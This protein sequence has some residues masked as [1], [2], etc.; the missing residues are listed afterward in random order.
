VRRRERDAIDDAEEFL[1]RARSAMHLQA[2][3]RA[4]RLVLDLQPEV[5]AAM[6]FGDEP[7]LP[8]VDGLMR[9]LFEHARQVEHVVHAVFDRAVAD[10][11]PAPRLGSPEAVLR[12]VAETAEADAPPSASLLDA[13]ENADVPKNVPWTPDILAAFMRILRSGPAGMRA[14][15]A[16]DRL[17]VLARFLPAW[18]DVRCRPQ[19]DP[20]HRYTVDGHLTATVG[21]AASLLRDGPGT[22]V[23]TSR[24]DVVGSVDV[25]ENAN[26]EDARFADRIDDPDALLLGGL[27]HDVGKIGRGDHV[28]IG[29]RVAS[30][31]MEAMGVPRETRQLATF[32]VEEH[33]LLPDTATR[34]DLTDEN[35]ILD[36]AARIGTV[37]RLSALYLLTVADALATGPAAWTPWRTALIRDLVTKVRHVLERGDMGQELATRL[38]Q[39]TDRL[40]EMLTDEPDAAVDRFV[41]QMPRAYFLAVEPDRAARHFMTIAP[42]LGL[43]EVRTTSTRGSR[44]ATYELLVVAIDRPG[45][46]SWIAGALTLGGISILSAQVFTTDDGVAVDLFEVEGA[47]ETV[48]GEPRWREFRAMLRRAIDGSVSLERRVEEKRRRYPAPSAP[49]PVTVHVDNDASDFSSVIEVGAPDRIGLLYDVTRTLAD[50]RVDVHLAKVSTLGGRV[51]DAFYVRDQLGRKITDSAQLDELRSALVAALR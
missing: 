43:N 48:I 49:S 33:L 34:R 23:D 14:L 2:G 15:E 28:P 31:S 1:V 51:V 18:A 39:R 4:D 44:P 42:Q 5:A 46:L 11:E 12:A 16:L 38:V 17:D 19:R 24:G 27:F 30:S 45:L 10:A 22:R 13:I 40:R 20:Y 36:V 47:F 29:A 26:A 8:A 6:G 7:G 25:D 37:D 35:L 3:K 41:L 50:L 9:A 32:L 21:A